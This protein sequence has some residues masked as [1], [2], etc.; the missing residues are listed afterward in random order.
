[1]NMK[2]PA[3]L[4][5]ILLIGCG[6]GGGGSSAAPLPPVT[7]PP[8]TTA[9]VTPS[10]DVEYNSSPDATIFNAVSQ[11]EIPNCTLSRIQHTM[12]ADLNNDN[13]KDI[14]MFVLCGDVNHP[15]Q[16]SDIAHDD[17]APNT[18]MAL[19]ADGYGSFEVNNIDTFGTNYVQIGGEKGGIAGFFTLL[20]DT[21]SGIGLP[22]ITYMISR[23]DHRRKRSDDW[24]NHFSQQGVFTADYNNTYNL[25]DLGEP[26]WA[27]GVAAVPNMNY[28]WDLLFGYWDNDYQNENPPMAYRNSGQDWLD[29]SDEYNNDTDKKKMSQHAYLLT[30]DVN[31]HR[32]F[33][34]V[35]S[36]TSTHAI[37]SV[38][39]GFSIYNIVQ[40][41]VTEALVYDT[42]DEL[43]CI[44]WGDP[45]VDQWCGR[46]EIVEI[47]GVHYFGGLAWDHFELWWPTP[48]SEVML[49]GFAA[50]TRL[51]DGEQYDANKEYDC[52]TQFEGGT[53]RVLFSL[54]GNRL[55]MQDNPFPEKFINGGGVHKQ[56]LDLNG[57][58]YMDYWSSGGWAQEGEPQIYINDKEGNLVYHQRGQLPYLPQ[59]DFCNS[60]GC[61]VATE[62]SFLGDLNGDG[63]TDLIQYHAGGHIP[64]LPE[65][66]QGGDLTP[67]ENK[68]GQISV[69]YGK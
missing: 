38:G 47:D 56:T 4:C 20:E 7:P 31:D 55:V 51:P 67:F 62:E 6:G 22:H 1:M 23:D 36:V 64:N 68:S 26:L 48:D 59:Q 15:N 8:S 13:H 60:A 19:I 11:L 29:V 61:I 39:Q 5:T 17:D 14:L 43:G 3:V 30:F 46:K 25:V 32:P 57:D 16:G 49:L 24:S 58:G 33:G 66:V 21:N 12:I 69:W 18:M 2:I 42:C 65:H 44:E 63:I 41:Q 27:Q 53:V 50:I 37:G 28:E 52:D 54:E 10:F 45:N 9:P 34:E 40:G 35:K